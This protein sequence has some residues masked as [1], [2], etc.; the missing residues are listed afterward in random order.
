MVSRAIFR[1]NPY[2]TDIVAFIFPQSYFQ[3]LIYWFIETTSFERYMRSLI[4]DRVIFTDCL[5]A[6]II[7]SEM[8]RMTWSV[9]ILDQIFSIQYN[10]KGIVTSIFRYNTGS[11]EHLKRDKAGVHKHYR[12]HPN[13]MSQD[14]GREATQHRKNPHW[15][16]GEPCRYQETA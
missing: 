10:H 4:G 15:G 6:D 11:W 14:W 5:I 9:G 2:H 12:T 7:R 13:Y 16:A 1:F 3:K 8:S